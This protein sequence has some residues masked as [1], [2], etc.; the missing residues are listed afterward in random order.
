[1]INITKFEREVSARL[2]YSPFD[3]NNKLEANF[4]RFNLHSDNIDNESKCAES[5]YNAYKI[6]T[7]T[8]KIAKI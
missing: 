7:Y 1:M 5:L 4:I 2:E 8:F 6:F 3:I